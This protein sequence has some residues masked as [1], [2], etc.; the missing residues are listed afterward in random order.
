MSLNAE[1]RT[2][3]YARIE[4][5][6]RAIET[7]NEIVD[8]LFRFYALFVKKSNLINYYRTTL[9]SRGIKLNEK[10]YD[11]LYDDILLFEKEQ[12]VKDL[13][14]AATYPILSKMIAMSEKADCQDLPLLK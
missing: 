14:S 12:N 3:V 1:D 13:E 8:V 10:F 11:G 2:D 7:R 5:R 4:S 9:R 6:L